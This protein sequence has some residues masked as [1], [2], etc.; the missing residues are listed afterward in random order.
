LKIIVLTLALLCAFQAVAQTTAKDPLKPYTKCKASRGLGI[1]E[2]RR[3][4][5]D[6]KVRTITTEAGQLK[7]SVIDA[8]RVMFSYYD[9][10]YP[11][12]NAKIEASDP[13]SY[14]Q[15][16]ENVISSLK[17]LASHKQATGIVF[18]DKSE[19]NGFEHYGIDRDQ[20]DVGETMGTHVLFDDHH[21][22]IV[23]IYLLNQDDK[24]L[25]KAMAGGARR[26]RDIDGYK[27]LRDEFLI[28]YSAC[29]SKVAATQ[30]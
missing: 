11:F 29:L 3:I 8:Y 21:H 4:T 20:I 15:D 6:N 18:A 7:V 5:Y 16:K 12:A 19:L 22:L 28:K 17:D 2:V 23:T 13:A 24:S 1:S 30:P 26:F 10:L 25:L 14:K 27:P 9:L